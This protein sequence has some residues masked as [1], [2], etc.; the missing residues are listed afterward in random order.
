MTH[1]FIRSKVN[2]AYFLQIESGKIRVYCHMD[3]YSI[4]ACGGGGWTMVMKI[5]GNKV[6]HD[7]D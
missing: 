3:N 5:D 1:H 6:V 7:Y 4:E 2:N